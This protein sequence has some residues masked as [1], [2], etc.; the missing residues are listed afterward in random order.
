MSEVIQQHYVPQ[1]ILRRFAG[2]DGML[3]VVERTTGKSW[4]CGPGRVACERH[5]NAVRDLDGQ[6][7]TQSVEKRLAD[8]ES[9]AEPAIAKLLGGADLS[10]DE[11]W[12]LALFITTQDFR[13]PRQRQVFADLLLAIEH[14]GLP[15]TGPQS[16]EHYTEIVLQAARNPRPFEPARPRRDS[17]L[18]LEDDG[19]IAVAR[20]D[21]VQVLNA[22]AY[23][24]PM[25][26]LMRW[27]LLRAPEGKRYL[28]SDSPVQLSEGRDTL[29]EHTGPGYWRPD[30][31]ISFPLS[32]SEC[33]VAQRLAPASNA[34]GEYSRIGRRTANIDE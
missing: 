34:V 19:N 13:S 4:R 6:L 25:V 29:P 14:H 12:D 9:R 22:A 17:R 33:L 18:I 23:M 24:A 27:V 30:T 5:Y 10:R 26:A 31:F 21:T 8:V 3:D 15:A 11:R 28:L 7:D 1:M 16:I 32:P 2:E 20:E